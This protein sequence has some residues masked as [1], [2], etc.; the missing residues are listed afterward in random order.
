MKIMINIKKAF[1]FSLLLVMS[2]CIDNNQKENYQNFIQDFNSNN[3]LQIYVT[4]CRVKSDSLKINTR[5]KSVIE[6]TLN[7]TQIKRGRE[8]TK[9]E[10]FTVLVVNDLGEY[11]I[12]INSNIEGK[13]YYNY[14]QKVKNDY[15]RY[16]GRNYVTQKQFLKLKSLLTNI[17]ERDSAKKN[18]FNGDKVNY[19]NSH[20]S[21]R[22]KNYYTQEES[23]NMLS[24]PHLN[25]L[26]WDEDD[27]LVEAD[28]GGGG[29]AYYRYDDQ[30]Q[31]MRKVIVNGSVK[32]QRF[33]IGEWEL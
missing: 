13:I 31:R 33:Y 19:K 8:V 7:T 9:E 6:E 29:T 24:T 5:I 1:F 14:F 3:D 22:K 12:I 15:Y 2:N 11:S 21:L 27:M 4:N 23:K 28:L 17:C 16:L 32:K 20:K 10:L 18:E 30:G 26:I 25:E